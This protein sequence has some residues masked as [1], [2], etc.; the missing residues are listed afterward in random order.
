MAENPQ[1]IIRSWNVQ[2]NFAG[3]PVTSNR[4]V[5][6]K[7]GRIKYNYVKTWREISAGVADLDWSSKN[8]SF[9]IP[10]GV[11]VL[12]AMYL[13][14]KLPAVSGATY[15][16][17][18]GLYPIKEIRLVSGGSEVYT[19]PYTEFLA[20]HMQS[21]TEQCAKTFG[22]AYL[23]H[24]DALSGDARDIMCPILL[25][26]SAYMD[27]AGPS[28]RGHG[29]LPATFGANDLEIQLTMHAG[30]YLTS[31]NSVSVGSIK[32]LC[33]YMFH[34]VN[35]SSAAIANLQD[36]RGLY[37][38]I[39]RRF[40]ELTSGWQHYAVADAVETWNINQP[41]GVVTETILVACAYNA[42]EDRHSVT[43]VKPTSFKVTAD[44]IV[45]KDLDTQNKIDAELWTNGFCSP[46]DF[47]QPGRL[48][49]AAQVADTPHTY[50][51]GYNQQLAS[52]IQY[53][54]TFAEAVS[55]KL[56]AVQIQ[57]V[58]IDGAGQM[59]ASLH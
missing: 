50:A 32:G 4:L 43:Y 2:T 3:G 42:N 41:Q 15:K 25:P 36:K 46:D 12:S 37:S 55:Y 57:R 44:S 51:G 26:N 45:Q 10:S 49:F 54:F 39:N 59:S 33:S 52:S 5:P 23:G 18:P 27:R 21:L 19:A 22:K 38:I 28:T 47:P 31:D 13:R 16:N 24:E 40:T 11:R 17:Y 8:Y 30:N 20:D 9:Y 53:D 48:C 56:F 6:P 29:I 14:I 34:E 35:S 1:N 58:Q 7:Y